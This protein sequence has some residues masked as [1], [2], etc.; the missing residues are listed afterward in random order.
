MQ[1]KKRTQNLKANELA[2][3]GANICIGEQQA[4][5]LALK[6]D[7]EGHEGENGTA[8]QRSLSDMWILPR[9][10]CICKSKLSLMTRSPQPTSNQMRRG[11]RKR[12]QHYLTVQYGQGGKTWNKG[13]YTMILGKRPVVDFTK[14]ESELTLQHC[15]QIHDEMPGTPGHEIVI[16]QH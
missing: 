7:S 11:S 15:K 4:G 10:N 12:R 5:K 6:S 3:M 16:V 2:Q 9:S 13:R 14:A 8:D 1:T